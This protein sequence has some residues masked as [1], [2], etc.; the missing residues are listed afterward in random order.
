M[1][2][3]LR[4]TI[5]TAY[6]IASTSRRALVAEGLGVVVGATGVIVSERPVVQA[7]SLGVTFVSCGLGLSNVEYQR[8]SHHQ[9][10]SQPSA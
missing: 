2:E 8:Y 3:T 4:T 7:I 6:E 1:I 10:Q 5:N 9:E